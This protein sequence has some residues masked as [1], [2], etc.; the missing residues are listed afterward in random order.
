MKQA[1]GV[2][3][4]VVSFFVYAIINVIYL[5]FFSR[6]LWKIELH[7]FQIDENVKRLLRMITPLL[8]GYAMPIAVASKAPRPYTIVT[9]SLAFTI[10]ITEIGIRKVTAGFGAFLVS[11]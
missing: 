2:R 6:K 11:R 4:L 1:L 3:S 10:V 9:I 7:G 8:F 5:G